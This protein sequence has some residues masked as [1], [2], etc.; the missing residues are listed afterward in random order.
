MEGLSLALLLHLALHTQKQTLLLLQNHLST[1]TVSSSRYSPLY[2]QYGKG[3]W[4]AN[5]AANS[6][7]QGSSVESQRGSLISIQSESRGRGGRNQHFLKH[8]RGFHPAAKFENHCWRQ[9]IPFL[10]KWQLL[11]LLE[12]SSKK[13]S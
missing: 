2:L 13:P 4:F 9:N 12:A 6:N 5:L 8:H 1:S 3:Q 11:S 10:P 7:H